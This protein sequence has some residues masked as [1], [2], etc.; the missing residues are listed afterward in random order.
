MGH[1]LQN[2]PVPPQMME[3][4]GDLCQNVNQLP[5]FFILLEALA[6]MKNRYHS[7]NRPSFPLPPGMMYRDIGLHRIS[8]RSLLDPLEGVQWNTDLYARPRRND[9][10]WINADLM[11]PSQQVCHTYPTIISQR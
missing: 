4:T 5:K 9:P 7:P 1:G 8:F 6:T 10:Y 11:N 2:Q 3:P